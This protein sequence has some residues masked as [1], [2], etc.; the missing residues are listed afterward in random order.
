MNVSAKCRSFRQVGG[1]F[2]S[3]RS[4]G[5]FATMDMVISMILIISVMLP[6]GFSLA[7]DGELYRAYSIRARAMSILD[8]EMEVLAAGYW[9][10]FGL[11]QHAYQPRSQSAASMTGEFLLSVSESE[12]KLT[13]NPANRYRGGVVERRIVIPDA[14]GTIE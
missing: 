7:R 2:Q 8:G 6:L 9:R 11:G 1:G 4:R 13:W 10:H 5:G 3:R 14:G 12:L